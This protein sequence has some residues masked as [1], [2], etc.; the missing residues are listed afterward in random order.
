M[1]L[2]ADI[3]VWVIVAQPGK[4]IGNKRQKLQLD[5]DDELWK[6]DSQEV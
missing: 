5:L 6:E 2:G 3:H 1:D 4:K